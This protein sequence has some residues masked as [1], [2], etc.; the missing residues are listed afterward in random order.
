MEKEEEE[1]VGRSLL[2]RWGDSATP[3]NR[4]M[5]KSLFNVR[6]RPDGELDLWFDGRE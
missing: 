5:S 3:A 6:S 2:D 4:E 1:G